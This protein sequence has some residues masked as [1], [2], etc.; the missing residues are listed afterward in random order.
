MNLLPFA[1]RCSRG[2]LK[3]NR[4]AGMSQVCVS[5][6]IQGQCKCRELCPPWIGVECARSWQAMDQ[7]DFWWISCWFFSCKAMGTLIR[8]SE[9]TTD[10]NETLRQRNG[11]KANIPG[12]NYQNLRNKSK[13][14]SGETG[15]PGIPKEAQ[16][17]L[18]SSGLKAI[19]SR[20]MCLQLRVTAQKRT[21]EPPPP[22]PWPGLSKD[23]S[24]CE[25]DACLLLQIRRWQWGS[26]D[27]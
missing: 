23:C 5:W 16:K 11:A 19:W 9:K 4:T 13:F 2:A 27:R 12:I 3:T 25:A 15:D 17:S 20:I 6:T 10:T 21:R 7:E 8:R 24:L 22:W 1:K 26:V 14:C 18:L